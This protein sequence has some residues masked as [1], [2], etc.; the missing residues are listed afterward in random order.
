MPGSVWVL[1]EKTLTNE[2]CEGFGLTRVKA[3]TSSGWMFGNLRNGK[4]RFSQRRPMKLMKAE[5]IT[6]G[7]TSLML[8]ASDGIATPFGTGF[9]YQGR[10]ANGGNVATGYYDLKFSLFDGLSGG[11]QVGV[12][13]TNI[14]TGVS[15]GVFTVALD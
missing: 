10:L 13:Q 12:S 8:L 7:F 9:S 15:N 5:L 2:H 4:R 14:A 3:W 11:N 1:K 6:F